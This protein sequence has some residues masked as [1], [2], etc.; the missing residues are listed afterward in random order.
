MKYTNS[1]KLMSVIQKGEKPGV[2]QFGH[3]LTSDNE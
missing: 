3:D 2:I 1:Q